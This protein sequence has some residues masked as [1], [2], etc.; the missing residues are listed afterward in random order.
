VLALHL[1]ALAAFARSMP[2]D[3]GLPF[4]QC[5]AIRWVS[6]ICSVAAGPTM[7]WALVELVLRVK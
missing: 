3:R 4:P 7:K 5:Q 2:M 1:P 6:S